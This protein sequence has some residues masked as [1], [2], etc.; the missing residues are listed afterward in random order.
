LT[1]SA[2]HPIF[3]LQPENILLGNKHQ[4]K[5]ADFGLAINFSHERPVTRAGTLD[6]M[7]P[8]VLSCPDKRLPNENKE[9]QRLA[10]N[11]AVSTGKRMR[12]KSLQGTH[13]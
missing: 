1:P 8:E 3:F 4:I 2:L 7:A 13:S 6:Y 9:F 5:L 12:R 11:T 10:Y